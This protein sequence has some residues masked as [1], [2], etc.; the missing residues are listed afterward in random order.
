MISIIECF[1]AMRVSPVH[2]F[3]LYLI[4]FTRCVATLVIA[5]I[6]KHKSQVREQNLSRS[7]EKL[8][9][10]HNTFDTLR[11][12]FNVVRVETLNVVSAYTIIHEDIYHSAEEKHA[13]LILLPFHKQLS[14]EGSLE[15]TNIVYKDINQNVM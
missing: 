4:E 15:V 7:Q 9:S 10:I 8:E 5:H 13:S 6:R 11:E 14:L 2:I 12:A 3:A 1:N